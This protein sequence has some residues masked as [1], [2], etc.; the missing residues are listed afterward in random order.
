[1]T[2]QRFPDDYDGIVSGAPV[3]RFTQLHMAQLWSAHAT[4]KKPGAVLTREDLTKVGE[5]AVAQCDASDG[6]KDGIITDPRTCNFDPS[7]LQGFSPAKIEALKMIYQGPVNPRTGVPL[8]A[9]LEPGG[10]GPQP[11]NPGWGLIMNGETP[12]AI[13]NAVLGAMGFGDPNWDWR[14]FDFDRDVELVDAKLFGTLNAVDPDLRDFKKGGGKLI[15]WH[16]WNDPGVMPQQTID[17]FD[18]VVEYAG[19][20]MGGDGAEFTDEYLRLFML[21]GVGHCRGG[22]GP[23]QADWMAAL[24]GWVEQGK[25]P[26]TI[27]ARTVREGKTTMT[28]PLCPHPQVAQYKGR[29]DA[30]DAASFEC[31]TP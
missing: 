22:V 9:G 18:S 17:Y 23:D 1:M 27:T 30:N 10:E 3:N 8:Y 15:V 16:G 11:G 19:K 31:A 29:G 2:A 5:A 28:R 26:D 24:A 21:P 14:T 25:Q 13:D 20:A 6:L 7:K 12:F 4:L